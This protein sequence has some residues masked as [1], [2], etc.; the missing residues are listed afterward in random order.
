MFSIASNSKLFTYLAVGML[1]ENCTQLHNG[2]VLEWTT[3]VKDIL[4]EWGL[5]DTY[6]SDHVNL[7]DLLS[8]YSDW[9][10]AM[11]AQD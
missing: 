2:E 5:M 6:M 4:P 10:A 11:V 8:E 3:K 1:V 7:I 9:T